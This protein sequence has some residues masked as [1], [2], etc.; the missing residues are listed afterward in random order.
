[1]LYIS[2][3]LR[4]LSRREFLGQLCGI[5]TVCALGG[6]PLNR[7]MLPGADAGTALG[8]WRRPRAKVGTYMGWAIEL[9]PREAVGSNAANWHTGSW[10]MTVY[11]ETRS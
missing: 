10:R 4:I 2:W 1:M 8:T 6:L 9:E 7:I 11:A 3:V 5:A